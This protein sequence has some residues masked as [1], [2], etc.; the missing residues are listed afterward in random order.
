MKDFKRLSFIAIL[1][2]T[3]V[4]SN[5]GLPLLAIQWPTL[6]LAFIPIIFIETWVMYKTLPIGTKHIFKASFWSNL[7]STLF[8]IPMAWICALKMGP[9]IPSEFSTCFFVI[10]PQITKNETIAVQ[11]SMLLWWVIFFGTSYWIEKWVTKIIL[12]QQNLPSLD[13]NRAVFRANLCSY[14]M[15][16]VSNILCFLYFFSK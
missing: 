12:R 16:F 4:F 1:M 15:L 5:A 3:L 6:W 8:G 2:P 10:P 13:I 14:G 7:T 9:I 11:L